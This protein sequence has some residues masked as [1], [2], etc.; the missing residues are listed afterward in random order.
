MDNVRPPSVI[1][2]FPLVNDEWLLSNKFPMLRKLSILR[3]G[4]G[5][6]LYPSGGRTFD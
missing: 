3:G 5:I 4:G 6:K 1:D 2:L